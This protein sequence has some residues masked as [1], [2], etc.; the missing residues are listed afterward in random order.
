MNRT[1]A[2]G[3]LVCGLCQS[4]FAQIVF[5]IAAPHDEVLARAGVGDRPEL[6]RLHDEYWDLINTH[7]RP[8]QLAEVT[9]IFGSALGTLT[10]ATG[11]DGDALPLPDDRVLP[12][13]AKKGTWPGPLFMSVA[14]VLSGSEHTDLHAVGGIGY[15]QLFYGY[16]GKSVQNALVYFRADEQFVPLATTNEFSKR[17]A[18][19]KAKFD[20][21]KG[22]L[23]EHM[24]INDLGVVEVSGSSPRRIELGGG[25]ACSL[26]TRVLHAPTVTNLWY[27]I[28]VRRGT[29]NLTGKAD[30]WQQKSINRPGE[31]IGFSMDGKFYRLTPKLVEQRP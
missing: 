10:N 20:A 27:T 2:A 5:P 23:D 15:V 25:T 30:P 18:W 29:P 19:E 24:P 17:L 6:Q 26:T 9:K 22:W 12:I 4:T 21:L 1:L 28:D 3:F 16:D 13:F 14:G 8:R 11:G 7:F 31:S